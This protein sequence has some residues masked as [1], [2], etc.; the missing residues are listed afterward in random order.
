MNRFTL[1]EFNTNPSEPADEFVD[2]C[3]LVMYI[4]HDS[5]LNML[6]KLQEAQA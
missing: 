5:H 6:H 4:S 2:F 1:P 3:P